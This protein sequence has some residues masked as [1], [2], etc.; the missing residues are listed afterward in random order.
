[1]IQRWDLVCDQSYLVTTSETLFFVGN[2]IGALV[3]GAL[4]DWYGRK[5]AYMLSITLWMA[6]GLGAYF[7]TNLYLWMVLRCGLGAS[8]LAYHTASSIFSLELTNGKWRSFT[9]H[10]FGAIPWNVGLIMLGLVVFLVPNMK[11]VELGIAL[12]AVPMMLLWYFMPESPRW[13]LGKGQKDKAEKVLKAACKINKRPFVSRVLDKMAL[14]D[15]TSMK[16]GSIWDLLRSTAIRRNSLCIFAVWFVFSFSYFGLM[17]HTPAFGWSMYLVFVFPP[18]IMIPMAIIQPFLENK[19]GRKAIMT[20]PLLLAG[21]ALISTLAFR[22]GTLKWPVIVLS[23]SAI[24]L[25]DMAFANGYTFTRELYPTSVRT[26]AL[27]AASVCARF[28]AISAPYVALLEEY[29]TILPLIVYGTSLAFVGLV[30]L[31]IW[32]DTKNVK[33]MENLEECEQLASTT[34]SWLHPFKANKARR[35]PVNIELSTKL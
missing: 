21:V 16:K 7:S 11:H 19:L 1:V 15:A 25:V 12:G 26:T 13:L 14:E 34:N 28:G 18:F 30:S 33:I 35:R 20:F 3:I 31:W 4:A 24:C 32:P 27:A 10:I 2:L 22:N 17:Y 5:L 23:W 6:F 9:N 8:S 29:N